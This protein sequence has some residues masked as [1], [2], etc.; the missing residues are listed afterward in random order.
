[1][2]EPAP[3]KEDLNEPGGNAEDRRLDLAIS[4]ILRSGVIISSVVAVFGGIRYLIDHSSDRPH[5]QDF[6]AQPASLNTVDGVVKAITHGNGEA[7]MQAGVIL[8]LFTP[9]LRVAFSIFAFLKQ[10]DWVYVGVSLIVLSVLIYSLMGAK[11]GGG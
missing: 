10:R 5:Y 1:M 11:I 6:H 3:G 4:N 2:N 7:I 9:I 8:L